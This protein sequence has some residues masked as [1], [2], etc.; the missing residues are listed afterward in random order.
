MR[1]LGATTLALAPAH[2]RDLMEVCDA[3]IL[4]D[5]ALPDVCRAPLYLPVLQLLAYE[6]A[7]ARW[8]DRDRPA[9]LDAVVKLE[10]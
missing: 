6:R 10:E 3:V 9:H 2:D 5:Q 4:L 1:A 8:Q 7:M